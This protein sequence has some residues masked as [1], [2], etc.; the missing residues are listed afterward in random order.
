MEKG[1]TTTVVRLNA[2]A[3]IIPVSNGMDCLISDN[4]LEDIC[5]GCLVDTPQHKKSPI[6]PR[7]EEVNEVGVD[8]P[9]FLIIFE[10]TEQMLSH[11]HE[12]GCSTWSKD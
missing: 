12:R 6:E 3:K 1:I 9:E 2:V 10:I 11:H 5:G 7:G 4:L 8:R